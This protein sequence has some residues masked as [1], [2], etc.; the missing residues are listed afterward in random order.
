MKFILKIFAVAFWIS[1]ISCQKPHSEPVDKDFTY[2][3]D[4]VIELSISEPSGLALSVNKDAL[5][6]VSDFTGKIYRISFDG[7]LLNELPF[8]GVDMEGIDVDKESGEIYTVEEGLQRIDHLSQQGILLDNITSINIQAP[9]NDTGF[10]GIAKNKDTLYILFEKNPGLLIKYHIPSKNWTQKTLSFALDYSGIDYDDSDNTLWIVSH[11][12]AML[13]HCNL[14]GSVI[15]SQPIDIKQ[16]EGVAIDR[17][18]NV[19]WIVSDS[20]SKLHRIV[21]KI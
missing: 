12:S 7:K 20:N 21:L 5:Y 15:K 9:D 11:E 8:A 2:K 4:T 1:I 16:A 18:K 6:T 10:E 13:Y 14:S 19:A 3:T 17:K